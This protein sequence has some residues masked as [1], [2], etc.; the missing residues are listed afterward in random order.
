MHMVL[1]CY[2]KVKFIK[3]FVINFL[4]QIQFIKSRKRM[5]VAKTGLLSEALAQPNVD[6]FLYF[7][8][9]GLAKILNFH[10]IP[11]GTSSL[12]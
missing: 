12:S 9:S 6:R 2:A 11:L 10:M 5:T 1:W 8:F 7:Q 4:F 3:L